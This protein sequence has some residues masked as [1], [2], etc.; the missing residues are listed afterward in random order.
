MPTEENVN[1]P[2]SATAVVA[3]FADGAAADRAVE[4]LTR[5]GFGTDQVSFVAH[6]AGTV[7]GRFVPGRLMITVHPGDRE[8]DATRILREQGAREVKAGVVSAVG[9]VVEPGEPEREDATR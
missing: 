2:S 4:A 8:A 7:D 6:G 5:A 1:I 9:E 3:E